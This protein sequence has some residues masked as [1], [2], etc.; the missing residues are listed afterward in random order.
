MSS[1]QASPDWVYRRLL[2]TFGPQGWWPVCEG[3]KGKNFRPRYNPGQAPRLKPEQAFEIAVGAILTQNTAWTNVEK[4]L[5][6]LHQKDLLSP[7]RLILI[8]RERL[9]RA[10][11]PSGYFSQKAKKLKILARF[12]RDEAGCDLLSLK[13]QPSDSLRRRLLELWGVGPETA[14]SIL[15]YALGKP[16]FVVDA[17]TRRIGERLGW[18][19]GNKSYD[20]IRWFFEQNLTPEPLLYQEF[21]ALFIKLAKENCAKLRPLCQNCPLWRRCAFGRERS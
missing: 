3:A 10:I 18:P 16:V 5:I 21:H 14:D 2:A 15:L 6:Q 8:S 20:E 1:K 7:R 12:A 17:Y 4:A 9:K 11:R 19:L 13:N